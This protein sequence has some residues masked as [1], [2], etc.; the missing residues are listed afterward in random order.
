[1]TFKP[2]YHKIDGDYHEALVDMV[3]RAVPKVADGGVGNTVY[4]ATDD[5]EPTQNMAEVRWIVIDSMY[6]AT[7][8]RV[9]NDGIARPLMRT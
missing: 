3:R 6:D 5:L 9:D 1:M 4:M 8:L 7:V 2:Q